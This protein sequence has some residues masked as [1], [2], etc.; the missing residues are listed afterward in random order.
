MPGYTYLHD[1][2]AE[3]MRSVSSDRELNMLLQEVRNETGEEWVVSERRVPEKRGLFGRL[4][5]PA[6]WAYTLYWY[7]GAGIE[8]QVINL[9]TTNGGSVFGGDQHSRV[10]IK[11]Y[12]MG[13]LNGYEYAR[14]KRAEWYE[15]ARQQHADMARGVIVS[16]DA[17]P[18]S[19]RYTTKE[20]AQVVHNSIMHQKA[21]E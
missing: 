6:F 7:T 11:N 14:R 3:R 9:C 8:Y 13:I 4:I 10:H 15:A 20:L 1:G 18:K 17:L 12:L 19:E 16:S 2:E 21:P 5:R